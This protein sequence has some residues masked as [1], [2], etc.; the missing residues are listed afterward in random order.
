MNEKKRT[1]QVVSHDPSWPAEFEKE[2]RAISFILGDLVVHVH[3]I[4]S[5]AVPDLKAKPVIDILLEVTD[6]IV[7]DAHDAGMKS[8]GY[9]PKGE[10]GITGRRF[11][12]KG[13]YDR[14]HH[15]HAFNADSPDVKRH[16]A[17]RD[18]L[19]AHPSIA[20]DYEELKVRCASECN[21]DNDKYCDGK[22]AFVRKHE[23][24]AEEWMRCQ[25]AVARDG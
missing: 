16:I 22:D 4:G 9:T 2:A 1:I 15:V 24:R 23:Q 14:T 3:H 13:L 19:I 25:Q 6:V 7:L 5:T 18:Y 10:F 20:K 8:L 11:Y 21:N 12:L 17:F